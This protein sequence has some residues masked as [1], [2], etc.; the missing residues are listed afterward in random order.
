VL[1]PETPVGR[2]VIE[3]LRDEG[4]RERVKNA[5]TDKNYR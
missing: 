3:V 1:L 5:N 4:W 2:F